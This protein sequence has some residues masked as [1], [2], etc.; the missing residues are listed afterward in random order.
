[1]YDSDTIK[2]ITDDMKR[3]GLSFAVLFLI[4]KIVFFNEPF[5]NVILSIAALYWILILPAFG[6][7]YLIEDLDFLERFVISVPLS[8][9]LVGIFSYYVGL[10]GIGAKG[11][12]LYVP[13]AF[14]MISAIVI[15]LKLRN[16]KKKKT[17]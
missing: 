5:L 7:T 9:A 12:T 10:M 11:W 4:L 14:I 6:I 17:E 15:Y 1:M 8:A 16:T 2:K 13:M 3:L